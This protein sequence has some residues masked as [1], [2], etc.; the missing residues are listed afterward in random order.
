MS[1]EVLHIPE[2]VY[3]RFRGRPMVVATMHGKERVI[4]PLVEE[5]LGAHTVTLS[6]FN[7]D[8]FG[9]FSG[10]V[11][12]Q[13]DSTTTLRKKISA[14]LHQSGLNL[15]IGTEASFGPHP[16]YGFIPGHQEEVMLIDREDNL[17]CHSI[18]LTT[19]TNYAQEVIHTHEELTSF[20][21][22]VGFPSH[23]IILKKKNTDGSETV[24]KGISSWDTLNDLAQQFEVGIH[25]VLAETDMRAMYNPTRMQV[26]EQTTKALIKKLSSLCPNC[27]MPGF[28]VSETQPGLPCRDCETPTHLTL[29][30][31]Y[32][33]NHCGYADERFYHD[34]AFA[35]PQYCDRCNP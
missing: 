4:T 28:S 14:A 22:R 18:T 33:C 30:K 12:R 26:I 7:S 17:E 27:Q 19:A 31:V 29:L 24:S 8:R 13:D 5:Y 25:P 11:A 34:G 35:D 32:S 21:T 23:G 6:E 9:T 2:Q 20:A 10:E 1:E 15:G 16:A 3:K